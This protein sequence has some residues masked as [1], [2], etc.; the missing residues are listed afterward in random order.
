MTGGGSPG[1]VRMGS[2]QPSGSLGFKSNV[3]E[4]TGGAGVG[5]LRRFTSTLQQGTPD[6]MRNIASGKVIDMDRLGQFTGG[7]QS[8]LS[9]IGQFTGSGNRQGMDLSKIGQFTGSGNRGSDVRQFLN[10]PSN[11]SS[12]NPLKFV[13]KSNSN[14]KAMNKLK[15][16][17]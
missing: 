13:G 11:Q 2:Q 16:F 9:K 4:F 15:R 1:Q 7:G 10:T 5:D 3:G 8:D 6:E 17:L 12:M 14:Q